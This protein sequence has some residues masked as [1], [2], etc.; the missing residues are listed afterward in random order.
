M[1]NLPPLLK[2]AQYVA[3]S[4]IMLTTLIAIVI[5]QATPTTDRLPNALERAVLHSLRQV[6][7]GGHP[8]PKNAVGDNGRA[9]GPYQIHRQ[10]WQDA[11]QF[12]PSLGGTYESCRETA[13]A[14]Q[15][16]LAYWDR[17]ATP[18]IKTYAKFHT[19]D[20]LA[21]A[22]ILARIHNGVPSGNSNPKTFAYWLRV[23]QH[24]R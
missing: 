15:V 4:G 22:E 20:R 6:E 9:I 5:S 24:L 12:R 16:I 13:Y 11:V 7:S 23:K 18:A 14:E 17:Y 8:D 3:D 21:T 19:L 1:G 10:Y 2:S